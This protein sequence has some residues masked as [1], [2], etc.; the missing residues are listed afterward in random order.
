M[1]DT[2]VLHLQHGNLG[3]LPAPYMHAC[4]RVGRLSVG[5][6]ETPFN[7]H[8]PARMF[9]VLSKYNF[10]ES[11]LGHINPSREE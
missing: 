9:E 5:S 8:C 11:R 3:S 1:L 7:V 10:T 6:L 2:S 4:S